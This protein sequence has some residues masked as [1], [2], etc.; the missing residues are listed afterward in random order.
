MAL[1]VV[2]GVNELRVSAF[3]PMNLNAVADL[4]RCR[5]REGFPR[6]AKPIFLQM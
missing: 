3:P 4:G 1:M 2:A 5:R 6:F